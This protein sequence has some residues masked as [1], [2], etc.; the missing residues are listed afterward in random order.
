M[1]RKLS[2]K[3]KIFH[4]II[5]Q[6]ILKAY[7]ELYDIFLI[8]DAMILHTIYTFAINP[9][10]VCLFTWEGLQDEGY[11]KYWDDKAKEFRSQYITKQFASIF[12]YF[13]T[14]SNSKDISRKDLKRQSQDGYKISV[15]FI[16]NISLQTS[17]IDLREN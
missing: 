16:F 1:R 11:I 6:G 3:R 5:H 17:I 2:P 8:K 4:I 13:K 9:Y 14:Y 10:T 15:T 7:F 12:I